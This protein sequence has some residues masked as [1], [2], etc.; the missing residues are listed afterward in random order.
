LE[1]AVRR[2]ALFIGFVS[3]L[4][5]AVVAQDKKDGGRPSGARSAPPASQGGQRGGSRPVGHG[6]IPAH[7]P[8]A[9]RQAP[10]ARGK[11]A[12]PAPSRGQTPPRTFRDVPQHPEAPHVHPETGAWIGHDAGRNDPRFH[13]DHPW[14]HGRFTLGI[15][16]RFVFRIEGG[17]RDRFWFQGSA[18]QIAPFDVDYVTD[19]NW[20]SDDVVI[21]DDP[22]HDGWYLAYN[23]RTGTYAH[24]QYMGPQ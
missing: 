4:S 5:I 9:V 6:Y 21:Y 22:D 3:I 20:Q 7:G 2:F 12:P 24:V 23:V 16:P 19:W 13:L 10:A 1:V 15:G 8:T 17:N 14:P 18:F 11:A